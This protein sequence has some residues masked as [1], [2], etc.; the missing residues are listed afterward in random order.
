MLTDFGVAARLGDPK[1][2]GGSMP[3][4]APE[5]LDGLILP[6]LDVYSLA[7][8][9][10][11]LVTGFPPFVGVTLADLKQ[12][13]HRGLPDLDARCIGLPEPLEQ[14]IRSGLTADFA[15]R[16]SLSDFVTRLRGTLNQLMADSFKMSQP[17]PPSPATTEH[18]PGSPQSLPPVQ[19][20]SP[21]HLS[22]LRLTCV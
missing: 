1:S 4:M 22:Q 19:R 10:Y 9:L 14:V 20:P 2:F 3:Y 5:A 6:S 11:H 8:T 18:A 15:R 21:S 12:Q 13:I 16:P 7:A 17:P